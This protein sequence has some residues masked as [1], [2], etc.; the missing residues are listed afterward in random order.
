MAFFFIVNDQGGVVIDIE[1]GSPKPTPG[2]PL[3]VN[4]LRPSGNDYQLWTFEEPDP[5]QNLQGY[6]FLQSKEKSK[7]GNHLVIDIKGG[8]TTPG[9]PLHVNTL[10][11]SASGVSFDQLWYFVAGPAGY[12]FIGSYLALA[13]SNP[14]VL[15]LV[16]D[17]KGA[18]TA[19][20]TAVQVNSLRSPSSPGGN[21]YQLWKFVDENGKTVR[22]PPGPA[23]DPSTLPG[24]NV[25]GQGGS[26]IPIT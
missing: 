13:N 7:E 5:E 2:T 8:S 11:P 14:G 10:E 12:C 23:Q 21:A 18:S 24:W 16:I 3:H 6:Y 25:S 17:V 22:L 19:P 20:G 15:P 26:A 4:T 9:T 1:G